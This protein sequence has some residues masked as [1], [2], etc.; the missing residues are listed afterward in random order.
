VNWKQIMTH[1]TKL[2]AIALFLLLVTLSLNYTLLPNLTDYDDKRVLELLL[3]SAA[4]LW[5][6]LGGM[7]T[8]HACPLWKTKTRCVIYLLL[9]LAGVSA[10]LSVS[11]RHAVLE[12]SVFAGLFYVCQLTA[13]LWREYRL[14][15]VQW[16]IYAIFVGAV[17]Y[18]VGFYTGYLASFLENIPLCYPEPF[19]GFNNVRA[20]NQ[21]QL[22]TLSL[23]YLP[24]LGFNIERTSIR[25]WMFVILAGWWVLLFASASRGVLL[26]WI[27]AML[28]T[29]GC[30]RQIA[31]PLLRLQLT[32]SIT[33]LACYGLLFHLLPSFLVSEVAWGQTV[34]RGTTGDRISLWKQAWS[35]I[36]T[37]P[38][39]G[40]G[41]MHYA[42]YP[43]AL[44]AHPH[45]S[46]LQLAAEWGLPA[47]VLM[48]VLAG[49]G[50]FCW[51]TRFNSVSLQSTPEIDRH[52]AVVLFFTLVAN[53][54]YSL[55]DGVIVMPLSQVM[56]AVVV[57][58]ILGLYSNDNQQTNEVGN[59]YLVHQIFA[60]V[61][62]IALTWSV[63]P[64]LLPR[65][66]GNEQMIPRGYQTIGPRFW[67]EG[68]IVH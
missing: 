39:F 60:G 35:M 51:L 44:A 8:V 47:T 26:A 41:P 57:G 65:L 6:I 31:W 23:L 19:F 27:L 43:N 66:L 61:I 18:M 16:M 11:P 3:I 25:R 5:I 59:K 21:Y 49:Y 30:Y 34:L 32:S 68:G 62:L 17:L 63:L 22:W 4:L 10:F 53:A 40:V 15:L 29:A 9:S 52:L 1:I 33:G 7:S 42:W 37:H 54:C 67:Q 48:L 45:N 56:M 55:V 2:L 20:F 46:V 12:I 36:Q 64:E 38:W 14:T 13:V 50:V 24:L 28:A 58:L